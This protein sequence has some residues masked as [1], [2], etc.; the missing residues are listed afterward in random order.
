MNNMNFE[1]SIER[2]GEIVNKLEQGN[3]PLDELLELFAEGTQL[4]SICNKQLEEAEQKVT[5]LIKTHEG[6]LA[7]EKFEVG[8]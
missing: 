7:E 3:A 1:K 8:E 2:L 6:N 5:K 4:I